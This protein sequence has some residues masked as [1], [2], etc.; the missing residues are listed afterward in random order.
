MLKYLPIKGIAMNFNFLAEV[1][2]RD[3]LVLIYLIY[4]AALSVIAF[5]LYGIDKGQAKSGGYRISEKTLIVVAL[6]GGAIGAIFGRKVF[7]HK[8][9]REHWYFAFFNILGLIICMAV[10]AVLRFLI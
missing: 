5:I 9:R 1:L 2:F 4:V 10:F 3:N 6:I 8:T 7:R